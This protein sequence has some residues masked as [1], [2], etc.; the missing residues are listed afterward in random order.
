MAQ[1]P[2]GIPASQWLFNGGNI[3]FKGAFFYWLFA[4]R[5]GKLILGYWGIIIF[6]AGILGLSRKKTIFRNYFFL[7]ILLS[8]L[9]YL[10]IIA[11]GNVQHD[12]YQI[13]I[14][15]AIAMFL[16][17]GSSFLISLPKEYFYQSTGK[18]LLIIAT[19]FT[20]TFGWYYVRDYYNYNQAIV[21]AGKAADKIL[22]QDTKVIAIARGSEGDTTFL[23]H[24]NRSGWTSLQNPIPEMIQ[25]GAGYL[26]LTPPA[27][28][29]ENLK[30][31]YK[32]VSSTQDYII[33]D[34]RDKK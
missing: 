26:I 33:F 21:T 12:Y 15:P 24:T 32:V 29:D 4:E 25:K 30:K 20:V 16:G 22:P 28:N 2:E 1:F 14:M 5:I 11:R 34:L 3:R 8:A 23:Y 13:L 9:I 19:I 27:K 7:S 17:L 10:I 18:I 31:E 6:G